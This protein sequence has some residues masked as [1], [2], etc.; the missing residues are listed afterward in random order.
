MD[1]DLAKEYLGEM[2]YCLKF[3]YANRLKMIENVKIAF[4]KIIG[5]VELEE[6]INIHHN[7]AVM[8]NH[9]G[10]NVMIQRK[11][12][13]SAKKGEIGIIPG[14]QG[15]CSYIVEGLGNP[16]SFKSCSHGAGR[17]MGRKDACR[18]LNLEEEKKKLDEKGILHAIRGKN[19]LDEASGAYKDIDVVMENQKDLVK[20]LVKL[21]PLGVIKG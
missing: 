20:I 5:D 1:E 16:E 10:K 11:G 13:T 17:K 2:D 21:E 15:T 3:A 19:D 4:I 8:E 9:F 14:S 12:S 6:P 18:R 7:Y